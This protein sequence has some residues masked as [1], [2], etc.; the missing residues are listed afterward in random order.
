LFWLLVLLIVLV[1]VDLLIHV[2]YTRLVL[3][4]FETKPPF[5]VPSF[6]PNP[7]AE[8]VSFV[9]DDGVTLRGS[10]HRPEEGQ[11]K[12]L[13]LFCPELE[14]N[15]WS[16]PSYARGL[17]EAGF[18][19]MAFDFRSQ[20][21]SD[22]HP[23]YSPLHWPTTFEVEDVRAALRFIQSR[24]D[25]R[26]L[27]LGV[28]GISRGATPALILA[29]ESSQVKAV[30]CEGA[31]S[32]DALMIHFISR[33]ATLYVPRPIL[34]ILPMWHIRLTST[35]VRLTSQFLRKRRYVVLERWLPK[36]KDRSVLLVA[37]ERDNYVHPNVGRHLQRQIDSPGVQFWLV[38]AA[39]HN[40]A[41]E[42]APAE[43]DRR[44][45]NFFD[46]TLVASSA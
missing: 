21:E 45:Q 10:I 1:S 43:Y 16:A 38:P 18:G 2:V 34:K 46:Q 15:H 5:S 11:S 28:M 31:Y 30:C 19:I 44:L 25:L 12:G 42:V 29:A 14:G 36:L 37:G 3:R 13:I 17:L 24:E 32:T 22:V 41:R 27:P 26:D 23:G 6:P 9:T 7:A 35:F 20:G 33:W 4:I 39:K 40:R 8:L